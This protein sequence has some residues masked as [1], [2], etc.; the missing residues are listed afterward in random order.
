M[1]GLDLQGV[2]SLGR[3]ALLVS[4]EI[5]L[6]QQEFQALAVQLGHQGVHLIG[7][8]AHLQSRL[9]QVV[10]KSIGLLGCVSGRHQVAG[11]IQ[12]GA[13]QVVNRCC[14]RSRDILAG[15]QGGKAEDFQRHQDLVIQRGW[16][17]AQ[18]AH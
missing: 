16:I 17:V 6:S 10:I 14:A 9:G 8:I 11:E 18:V 15:L 7:H 5:A 13:R 12:P 3:Q 1:G 2:E 4:A